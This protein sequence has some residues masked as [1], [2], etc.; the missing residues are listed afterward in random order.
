MQHELCNGTPCE[1]AL[2]ADLTVALL[3]KDISLIGGY[4][5]SFQDDITDD[6]PDIAN[7]AKEHLNKSVHSLDSITTARD[8]VQHEY[9]DRCIGCTGL[10]S[11]TCR[12]RT[13]ISEEPSE[14]A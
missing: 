4:A 2:R 13:I 12:I 1:D 10:S 9:L 3:S 6:N 5:M 11:G 14:S 7:S 8:L